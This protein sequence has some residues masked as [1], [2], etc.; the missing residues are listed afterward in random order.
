M[1]MASTNASAGLG[2]AV[3][4]ATIGFGELLFLNELT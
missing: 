1:T 3:L 4:I 2:A